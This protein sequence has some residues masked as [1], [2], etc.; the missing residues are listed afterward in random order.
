MP[1]AAAQKS[2]APSRSSVWQSMMNPASLLLCMAYLTS[3]FRDWQFHVDVGARVVRRV[4][5]DRMPETEPFVEPDRVREAAVGLEKDHRC[6]L[7]ASPV[8][9]GPAQKFADAALL[10]AVR[11][12]HFR[13]L[14]KSLLHPDHRDGPD[15]GV[16][17]HCEEDLAAG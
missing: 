11:N 9:S 16:T 4:G 10:V 5:I 12:R 2:A 17:I 15:R 8:D 13:E 6:P 14:V 3:A 7:A 1:S